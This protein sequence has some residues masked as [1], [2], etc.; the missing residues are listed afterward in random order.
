MRNPPVRESRSM[1]KEEEEEEEE[2]FFN[3]CL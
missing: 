3:H 2:E 1:D